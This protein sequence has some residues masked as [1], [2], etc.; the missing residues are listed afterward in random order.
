MGIY[1]VQLCISC[2]LQRKF[3]RSAKEVA[4]TFFATSEVEVYGFLN[5]LI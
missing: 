2:I 4:C 5:E 1:T 3:F